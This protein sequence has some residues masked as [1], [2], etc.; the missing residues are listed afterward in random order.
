MKNL[1]RN[2]FRSAAAAVAMVTLPLNSSAQENQVLKDETYYNTQTVF[3]HAVDN[4]F[5]KP[6]M[7]AE[8]TGAPL[9]FLVPGII[10]LGRHYL[11]SNPHNNEWALYKDNI[12]GRQTKIVAT[13][14]DAEDFTGRLG[15]IPVSFNSA[16]ASHLCEQAPLNSVVLFKGKESDNSQIIVSATQYYNSQM[17]RTN[18]AQGVI[19]RKKEDGT[20]Q[21]IGD[22]DDIVTQSFKGPKEFDGPM[23]FV[24]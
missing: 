1:D 6:I 23:I 7:T 10:A 21:K 5:N 20:C 18:N 24:Q 9:Q 13:E 14:T 4:N 19:Y 17:A 3:K 8:A 16:S 12:D 15:S 2:I 22:I 11:L